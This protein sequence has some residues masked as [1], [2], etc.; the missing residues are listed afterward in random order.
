MVWSH[1]SRIFDK[2]IRID[3]VDVNASLLTGRRGPVYTNDG[4]AG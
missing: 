2:E 4:R 1:V 3:L